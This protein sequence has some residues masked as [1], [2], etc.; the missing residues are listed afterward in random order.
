LLKA[1]LYGAAEAEKFP[2][3]GGQQ[4]KTKYS[5]NCAEISLLSL[6]RGRQRKK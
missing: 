6:F 4:K 3:V 1:V 2:G 5:K